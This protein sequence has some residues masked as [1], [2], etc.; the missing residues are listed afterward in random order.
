MKPNEYTI[1]KKIKNPINRN[2]LFYST[3]EFLFEEEIGRD[4]I[5]QD[6]NQKIIL[7]RVDLEKTNLD[8]LYNETKKDEIVF[9]VP[10]EVPC[11]YNIN[12]ADLKTYEKSKNLGFF[13]QTGK[14]EFYVYQFTLDEL[15]IDINIGDYVGVQINEEHIEY[16]TVVDDG[17]NNFAN[18]KSMYGLKPFYRSCVAVPI[19]S[20]EFNGK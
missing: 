11:L 14:L 15:D 18:N 13:K 4:Y 1:N 2:N 5:E 10:I 6:V 19:D 8:T 3:D 20:N 7:F 16:F 17:K 12:D 9:K